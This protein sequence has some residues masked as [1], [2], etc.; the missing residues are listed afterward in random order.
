MRQPRK[1]RTIGPYTI[2]R[3]LGRG[4][5]GTVYRAVI[6]GT[7][8]AV[9]LKQLHPAEPL[10]DLLG[11]NKIKEIFEAEAQTMARLN[12]PNIV[13]AWD[14]D[15]ESDQPYFTMEYFCNN[16]GIMIGEQIAI[17]EPTRI[18][19][20]DKAVSYVVQVLQGLE[21]IHGKGIIHRDIKPYNLLVTDHDVIKI[22]D[23]GMSKH[24]RIQSFNAD[25]M[26]IGSPFYSAP[27]QIKDP[28]QADERSDL[29]SVGVVL[30]CLLTGEL[31][32]MKDFSLSRINP[33]YHY[34]WDEY[35][36]KAL[37]LDPDTRYQSA[38]EMATALTKLELHWEER[39]E[40]LH[41][42]KNNEKIKQVS[43][44]PLRSSP[45]RASGS[46]AKKLFS[47]NYIWQ[48]QSYAISNFTERDRKTVLDDSTGLIWQLTNSDYPVDRGEADTIIE[49]LNAIG[50]GGLSTWRLP[51]VNELLTV[52]KD[53]ISPQNNSSNL[54]LQIN[55]DW[56]WSCDRRTN[57][58][59]WYV[60]TGLGY[61][62]WQ[63]DSCRYYVQAVSS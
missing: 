27:E 23:F 41:R 7:G 8:K 48:P 16:L 42:M 13:Q 1:R 39:K 18:F 35:F 50:Y 36:I 34:E 38:S 17:T 45:V 3:T 51:T 4:G 30:Y 61:V 14:I 57:K 5:M 56:S 10:V 33:L 21:Y 31:P 62:G 29:Y 26:H 55:Q 49:T 40:Q 58:T 59:S 53:P 25:G 47:V 20:P 24:K 43:V 52:V 2:T 19:H 32:S 28:D 37:S 63:D 22:C 60:N 12:H 9:A 54:P 11:L 6:E 15:S 46:N 44:F